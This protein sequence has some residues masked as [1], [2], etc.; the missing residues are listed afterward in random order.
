MR[1]VQKDFERIGAEGCYFLSIVKAGERLLRKYVD[2]YELYVNAVDR[3]IIEQD[4]YIND[5]GK[6]MA[7]IM[8]GRW[9]VEKVPPEYISKPGEITIMRYERTD[10]GKLYSHFVLAT[11]D[12]VFVDYDPYGDSK[13]VRAGVMVSKRIL[14]Q[15]ERG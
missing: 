9:A 6:L 3:N 13:T 7:L 2:A 12:G 11:E 10:G 15:V 4:C 8:G 5:P 14:W 1:S